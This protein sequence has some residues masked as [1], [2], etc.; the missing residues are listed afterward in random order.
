[1]GKGDRAGWR[2]GGCLVD[3]CQRCGH[4]VSAPPYC[5][6]MLCRDCMLDLLGISEAELDRYLE[7]KYQPKSGGKQPAAAERE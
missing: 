6:E 2:R 3:E 7:K 1:M 5:I 4:P